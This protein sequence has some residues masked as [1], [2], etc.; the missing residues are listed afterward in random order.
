VLQWVLELLSPSARVHHRPLAVAAVVTRLVTQFA[1][2]NRI[3]APGWLMTPERSAEF[4][5]Q[6][7]SPVR[8]PGRTISLGMSAAM[9]LSS[10]A[11]GRPC[12][13]FVGE[14]PRNAPR[15]LPKHVAGTP[16]VR[17]ELSGPEAE[18]EVNNR[19]HV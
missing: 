7:S 19:S 9:P 15:D 1:P 17:C 18:S 14:Y 6:G 12:H 8:C 5:P 11:A 16:V 3:A 10:R 13:W 4:V 2:T